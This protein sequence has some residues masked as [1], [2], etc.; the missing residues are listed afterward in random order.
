MPDPKKPTLTEKQAKRVAAHI[1]GDSL[2]TIAA[3]EGVSKQAVAK[4][5][6]APAVQVALTTVFGAEWKIKVGDDYVNI[7]DQAL[8]VVANTMQTAKRAI[9]LTESYGD[10]TQQRIEYVTDHPT[11]LAAAKHILT[12]ADKPAPIAIEQERET[13]TTHT[14]ERRRVDAG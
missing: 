2:A 14:R 11:R 5:L 9:V 7:I 8:L 1:K 4:S 13:V 10:S 12:L 3:E 6:A